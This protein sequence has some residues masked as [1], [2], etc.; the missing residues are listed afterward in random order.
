MVYERFGDRMEIGSHFLFTVRVKRQS[1]TKH[2]RG[3]RSYD[4]RLQAGGLREKEVSWR[5][6][7]W[8]Q[9]GRSYG[10]G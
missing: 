4:E 8:G 10:D 5:S 2:G 9:V 7:W 1:T 3:M 6:K